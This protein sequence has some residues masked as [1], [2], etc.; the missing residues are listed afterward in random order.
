MS[1]GAA[2]RLLRTALGF[3]LE[4]LARESGLSRSWLGRYER[5]QV[6]ARPA[7]RDQALDA[8]GRMAADRTMGKVVAR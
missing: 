5:V 8:L 2:L 1:Y 3:T 7:R 6:E 4:Q